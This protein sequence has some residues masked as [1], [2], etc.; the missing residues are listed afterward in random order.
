MP[1]HCANPNCGREI[2]ACNGFAKAGDVIE[3]QDGTRSW[4]EV[5]EL[6]GHCAEFY[7]WTPEGTLRA[8][9]QEELREGG[10]RA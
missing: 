8:C 10:L 1:R 7:R 6:C 2:T 4:L 5:R 9:T 3:A